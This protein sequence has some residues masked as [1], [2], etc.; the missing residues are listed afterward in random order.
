MT[1]GADRRSPFYE[2]RRKTDCFPNGGAVAI[3]IAAFS[4]VSFC[5]G[6][7]LGYWVK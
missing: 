7:G 6:F 4:F 2:S 1:E 5:L 3:T